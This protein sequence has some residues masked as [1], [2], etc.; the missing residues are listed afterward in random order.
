[1]VETTRSHGTTDRGSRF[2]IPGLIGQKTLNL[3]SAPVAQL[4]FRAQRRLM[5]IA[6]QEITVVWDKPAE[7]GL[8]DATRLFRCS[9]ADLQASTVNALSDEEMGIPS[10]RH[11]VVFNLPDMFSA[12]RILANLEELGGLSPEASIMSEFTTLLRWGC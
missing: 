5:E 12:M 1:M 2:R 9:I 11:L 3:E 8:F 10:P 4:K 7:G 6:T